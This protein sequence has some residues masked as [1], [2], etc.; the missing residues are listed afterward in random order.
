MTQVL[1]WI[2]TAFQTSD[3]KQV[4]YSE[5]RITPLSPC[6]FSMEFF[7]TSLVD[8]ERTCWLPLFYNPVIAKGFPIPHRKNHELGIE[9]PLEMMATLNGA[10]Q[11][12][13]YGSG[14][15]IK[16][17]Y[18]MIVPV[19]RQQ[20]SIQWHLIGNTNGRRIKYSDVRSMC[21]RRLLVDELG[22]DALQK[23]RAFLAWWKK[24]ESYVGTD[25]IHYDKVG[26]SLANRISEPLKMT[27]ISIGFQNWGMLSLN[28]RVGLKDCPRNVSIASRLEVILD[29]AEEM[30]AC[31]YDVACKR[32]WLVSGTELLLYLVHLKHQKKPYM[33]Q[34]QAVN[35][36]FAEPGHNGSAT[37]KKVLMEM[38]SVPIFKDV[39]MTGEDFCVKHLIQ[40]L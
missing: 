21:P 12:V 16:G 10:E 31:L 17:F 35:L 24:S 19:K 3:F 5:P 23:S 11:A 7:Q 27:G 18:S 32:A 1:A 38:A 39:T 29:A 33:V 30:N 28:F 2:G 26:R 14:L 13:E 36:I 34:G 8:A 22:P 6:H 40:Q 9:M 20:D 15:L 37:C 4:Q 25:R